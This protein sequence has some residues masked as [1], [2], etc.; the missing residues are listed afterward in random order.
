M[1]THT[2]VDLLQD[3]RSRAQVVPALAVRI[4]LTRDDVALCTLAFASMQRGYDV[5]C[6]WGSQILRVPQAQGN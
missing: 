3:M 5:S 4:S 1:L 6:T 2:L